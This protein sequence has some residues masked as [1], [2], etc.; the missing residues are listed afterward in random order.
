MCT[1]TDGGYRPINFTT[2]ER[3]PRHGVLWLGE[4]AF[5]RIASPLLREVTSFE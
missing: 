2:L 4:V 3:S 5:L 1:M